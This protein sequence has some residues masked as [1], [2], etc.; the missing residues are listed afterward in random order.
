MGG[1][2]VRSDCPEKRKKTEK[3]SRKRKLLAS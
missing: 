1:S 2:I 3:K